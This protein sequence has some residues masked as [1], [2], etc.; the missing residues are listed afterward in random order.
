MARS[1]YSLIR[2]RIF[3]PLQMEHSATLPEEAL[4]HRAGVGH[5]LATA[6]HRKIVRVSRVFLPFGFAPAGASLMV[7]AR[8]LLTFARAHLA[9]GRAPN[10]ARLLSPRSAQTMR[11]MSVDNS[12]KGYTYTDGVGLG[13]MV[14]ADGLLHHAGGG[15]GIISTLYAHPRRQRAIAILT[16]G[17]FHLSWGLIC[18]L[19]KHWLSDAGIDEPVGMKSPR[20]PT[21]PI[22]VDTGRY[23]GVFEN[24]S[25]RY[26]IV[27][28]HG[29]LALRSQSKRALYEYMSTEPTPL[30]PLIA[31]GDDKFLLSPGESTETAPTDGFDVFAFRNRDAEGRMRH[32]GNGDRLYRRTG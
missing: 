11:L 15:P 31:L 4:L 18:D 10:G 30:S 3:V 7:S 32:L 14:C 22:D 5:Y 20:I 19:T 2:E 9:D 28:A 21:V 12:S 13:W 6:P 23:V 8:D 26:H 25:T 17:E 16:N 1:W 27:R 29:G 24:G